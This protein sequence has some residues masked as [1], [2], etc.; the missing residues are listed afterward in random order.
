[1]FRRLDNSL[2]NHPSGL[3]PV[4]HS[5]SKSLST[6]ALT[7]VVHHGQG[8][9]GGLNTVHTGDVAHTQPIHQRSAKS[10]D[11][12]A[13]SNAVAGAN[14][15]DVIMKHNECYPISTAPV[16]SFVSPPTSS[17]HYWTDPRAKSQSLDP[18][19]IRMSQQMSGS[20]TSTG[21]IHHGTVIGQQHQQAHSLSA[22]PT[23]ANAPEDCLGPL[24]N[25][26][27]KAYSDNGTPYFIDHNTRTTSWFDP[28]L[29]KISTSRPRNNVV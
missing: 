12:D 15:Q 9:Y 21:G 26:W 17:S 3:P 20:S 29:S 19:S 23:H 1:M 24:P 6:A 8:I 13:I 27:E 10:C 14:Q 18:I 11:F 16:N 28:R 7:S 25:G 5:Y 2:R 22:I 4:A